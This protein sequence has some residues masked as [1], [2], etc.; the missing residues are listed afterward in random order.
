[1]KA[2]EFHPRRLDVRPFAEAGEPIDGHAALGDFERLLALRHTEVT[3]DKAA[4]VRWSARGELRRRSG[5][6]PEVWLHLTG[7]TALSQQCQRCLETVETPL[8]FERWFLFV[9]SER[10]AAELDA[11]SEDDVLVIS[12]QFDL[13]E[14][15]ED[16][17]LLA[18]PIVPRHEVCPTPVVLSTG[19]WSDD[20]AGET[21]E[22]S[23]QAP[24]NDKPN[25]FAVLASLRKT[26]AKD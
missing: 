9:D 10:Q 5:A 23:A 20:P 24:A 16:E 4:P 3:V 13:L 17:L 25:P 26:P 15:V 19:D 8:A 14:L 22:A 21:S 6:S 1:M 12:R 2:R 11:E 7:A 18:A